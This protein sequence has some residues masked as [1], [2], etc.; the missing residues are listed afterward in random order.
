V[1]TCTFTR[2]DRCGATRAEHRTVSTGRVESFSDGVLAVA[3][4]LLVLNIA[5]PAVNETDGGVHLGRLLGQQWPQYAAYATSF[6]T[7][8]IIWIN[9]HAMLSRLRQVDH[10]FMF[11]NLLLLMA[12][13]VLPFATALLATYLRAGHGDHLAAAIYGGALLAMGALFTALNHHVLRARPE[14]LAEDMPEAERRR[15]LA[16]S[17]SG[18]TPYVFAVALAPVSA[19]AT[20]GISAAVAVFYALPQ[21]SGN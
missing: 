6:L 17:A 7:V 5:V 14:L 1:A 10:F 11:V 13:A 2:D 12:V 19:F 3:I 21:A 15:I 20:L 18:V 16:R 4:T 8:G 9:H